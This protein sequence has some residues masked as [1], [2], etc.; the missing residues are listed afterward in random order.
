LIAIPEWS[1][2]DKFDKTHKLQHI[3]EIPQ[4][5]EPPLRKAPPE[6]FLATAKSA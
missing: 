2:F 5:G 6:F 4:I 3:I 1:S